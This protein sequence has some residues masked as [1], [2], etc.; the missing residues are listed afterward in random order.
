MKDFSN[1]LRSGAVRFRETPRTDR[2]DFCLTVIES[3]IPITKLPSE[4]AQPQS[5]RNSLHPAGGQR[6]LPCRGGVFE[7]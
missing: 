1:V 4:S 7:R 3:A 2:S 6:L 5:F